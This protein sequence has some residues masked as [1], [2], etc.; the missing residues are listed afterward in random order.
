MKRRV[1]IAEEGGNVVW[2]ANNI[3]TTGGF[4]RDMS[5][6]LHYI[7]E[8]LDEC[9]YLGGTEKTFRCNLFNFDLNTNEIGNPIRCEDCYHAC[10]G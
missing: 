9:P 2:E 7:P 1:L 8:N 6:G 4:C 3:L 10:G 5:Y